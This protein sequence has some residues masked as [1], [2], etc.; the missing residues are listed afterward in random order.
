[1]INLELRERTNDGLG[2][3]VEDRHFLE[4][5]GKGIQKKKGHY[6]VPL[7]LKMKRCFYRTIKVKLF[8][9]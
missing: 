8:T 5:V 2:L 4:I 6:E 1:M 7:P 9:V 3:S